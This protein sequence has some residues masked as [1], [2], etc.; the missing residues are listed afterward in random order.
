M[1]PPAG[2]RARRAGFDLVLAGHLHGGQLVR[3][4]LGPTTL[5][6]SRGAGDSLPLRWRCPREV[7]LCEIG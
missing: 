2:C 7:V 1:R 3:F 4:E 5:I 6:V